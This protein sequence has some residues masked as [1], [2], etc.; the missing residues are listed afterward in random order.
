MGRGDENKKREKTQGE[1]YYFDLQMIDFPSNLSRDY[2]KHLHMVIKMRHLT[3]T[4]RC[5]IDAP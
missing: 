2:E 5:V 1:R 4:N 3:A